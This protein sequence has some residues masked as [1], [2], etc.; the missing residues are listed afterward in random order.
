MMM[1]IVMCRSIAITWA[2][3][4]IDDGFGF[5]GLHHTTFFHFIQI[6]VGFVGMSVQQ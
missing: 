1:T 5:S 3:D 6:S 2:N 4:D